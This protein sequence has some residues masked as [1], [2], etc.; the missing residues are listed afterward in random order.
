[1]TGALAGL[2]FAEAVYI[3]FVSWRASRFLKRKSD[4]I[5]Q[6]LSMIRTRV[7]G[8]EPRP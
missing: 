8:D 2:A 5:D 3:V 4:E 7:S 6:L 1:M